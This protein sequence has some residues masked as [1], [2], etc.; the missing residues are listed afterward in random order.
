[1]RA[2]WR[3]MLF[4]VCPVFVCVCVCVC[5]CRVGKER[6]T[7]QPETVSLI[8]VELLGLRCECAA[9]CNGKYRKPPHPHAK[10]DVLRIERRG[11]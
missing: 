1:M 2:R 3:V 6:H 7:L 5:V 8:A 9:E 4:C 10:R 11:G